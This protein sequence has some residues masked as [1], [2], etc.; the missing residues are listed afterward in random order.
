MATPLT[1]KTE[2]TSPYKDAIFKKDG[3]FDK[4]SIAIWPIHEENG[5]WL[6]WKDHEALAFSHGFRNPESILLAALRGDEYP[7]I[8]WLTW[9]PGQADAY[10][11]V[12]IATVKEHIL[13]IAEDRAFLDLPELMSLDIPFYPLDRLGILLEYRRKRY[14]LGDGGLQTSTRP[15]LSR[16]CTRCIE[17]RI[18]CDKM[19]PSCTRCLND[20]VDC[21]YLEIDEDVTQDNVNKAPT[22]HNLEPMTVTGVSSNP[23]GTPIELESLDHESLPQFTPSIRRGQ[24]SNS[25]SAYLSM[26]LNPSIAYVDQFHQRS[27]SVVRPSQLALDEPSNLQGLPVRAVPSSSQVRGGNTLNTPY[28][29]AY[30]SLSEHY[31]SPSHTH[32]GTPT[33]PSEYTGPSSVNSP[34]LTGHPSPTIYLQK[35]GTTPHVEPIQANPKNQNS[36]TDVRQEG[37]DLTRNDLTGNRFYEPSYK[38]SIP[39]N[40]IKFNPDDAMFTAPLPCIDCSEVGSHKWDCNIGSKCAQYL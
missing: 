26:E 7:M 21:V 40:D 28:V 15:N 9:I 37:A 18:D 1:R 16:H 19:F 11:S 30:L 20:H 6:F 10:Q 3:S 36:P 17:K 29:S 5:Y 35:T 4:F 27:S 39:I 2:W 23:S 34:A 12:K 31:Q 14:G 8:I 38:L 32:S 13:S 24:F 25:S 33:L 22:T